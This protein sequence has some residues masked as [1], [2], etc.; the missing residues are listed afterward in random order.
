MRGMKEFYPAAYD[1]F[2]S[3]VEKH[4]VDIPKGL[5]RNLTDLQH[6]EL[7]NATIVH[8]KPLTNALGEGFKEILTRE[9]VREIFLQM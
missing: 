9:R 3:C 5:C 2:W 1:E 4:D 7:F 8:E 6:E